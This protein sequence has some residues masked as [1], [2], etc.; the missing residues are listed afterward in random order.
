MGTY[1]PDAVLTGQEIATRIGLPEFVVLEKM[2]I[3]GVQQRS[4]GDRILN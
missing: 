2:G 4:S 1:I 3:P